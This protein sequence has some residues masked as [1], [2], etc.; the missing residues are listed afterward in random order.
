VRTTDLLVIFVSFPVDMVKLAYRPLS[1]QRTTLAVLDLHVMLRF[2][3]RNESDRLALEI[4][5]DADVLARKWR[6]RLSFVCERIHLRAHHK[7]LVDL[8]IHASLDTQ[9]LRFDG[10]HVFPTGH[11]V[12]YNRALLHGSSEGRASLFSARLRGDI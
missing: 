10:Q 9:S 7:R 3:Y 4:P 8:D 2:L 1:K 6:G 11:G 12:A 5:L